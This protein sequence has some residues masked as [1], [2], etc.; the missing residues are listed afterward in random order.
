MNSHLERARLSALAYL[1]DHATDFPVWLRRLTPRQLDDIAALM[2][3]WQVPSE[4]YSILAI[5]ELEK[6]EVLRVVVVCE[7][8]ISK[9]A[10]LLK[11]GKTTIYRKLK[12]WGY[13]VESRMLM[14]QALALSSKPKPQASESF[15]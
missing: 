14:E 4:N 1:Y 11:M 5:D 6:R 8:N 9:A 2:V 13:S 10:K 15:V 12:K 7:G 3:R